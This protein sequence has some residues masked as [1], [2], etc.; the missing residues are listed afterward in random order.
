[1]LHALVYLLVVFIVLGVGFWLIDYLPVPQPLNKL[2]KIVLIVIGVIAIV[3]TLLTVV[4]GGV[5]VIP[6]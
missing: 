1:M 5:P 4:G 6:S 3:Y 2:A